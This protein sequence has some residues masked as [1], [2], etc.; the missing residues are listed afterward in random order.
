M[1]NPNTTTNSPNPIRI[2]FH[3][4]L[5]IRPFKSIYTDNSY[6]PLEGKDNENLAWSIVYNHKQLTSSQE[7]T[8]IRKHPKSITLCYMASTSQ[9]AKH[10]HNIHIFINNPKTFTL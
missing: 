6:I 7:A 1:N 4:Q 10:P 2:I 5:Q 3:N 9:Y 8:Q